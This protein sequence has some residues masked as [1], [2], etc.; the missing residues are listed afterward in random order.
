MKQKE[1]KCN[2]I[3]SNKIE[4]DEIERNGTHEPNPNQEI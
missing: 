1:V 2:E 3:K 4:W